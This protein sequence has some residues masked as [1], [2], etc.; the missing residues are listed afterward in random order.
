SV[1]QLSRMM[2][3]FR[4]ITQSNYALSLELCHRAGYWDTDVIP[5]DSHMFFK[6]LF[7]CGERV[8]TVPLYVPVWSDAAEGTR[9]WR[10]V[11]SHYRQA[12][13]GAR[14]VSDVPHLIWHIVPR[15]RIAPLP[16]PPPPGA[17][18][19]RAFSLP[20]PPVF[21]LGRLPPHA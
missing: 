5:E 2:V 10:T 12:R 6:A 1:M 15:R 9:W 4:P 11:L 19:P 21:L 3:G 20:A 8:R 7:R 14:G 17:H 18:P 13:R 16:P